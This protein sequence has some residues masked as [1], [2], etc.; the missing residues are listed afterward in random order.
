MFQLPCPV[1]TQFYDYCVSELL[2][3][4][5]GLLFTFDIFTITCAILKNSILFK[6]SNILRTNKIDI[7]DHEFR[8]VKKSR[9]FYDLLWKRLL[10]SRHRCV[11][12]RHVAR[13]AAPAHRRA[14]FAPRDS[15]HAK[16][17]I[18]NTLIDL[19]LMIYVKVH[20]SLG[21]CKWTEHNYIDV[22]TSFVCI[23]VPTA[24][25]PT[26][27]SIYLFIIHSHVCPI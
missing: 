9:S 8:N 25:V 27:T 14:S 18:L 5:R 20:H 16:I 26:R 3:H 19:L 7:V 11:T 10:S 24:N 21:W 6:K 1:F 17:M 23:K 22:V 13:K 12:N 4:G 15:S 2:A